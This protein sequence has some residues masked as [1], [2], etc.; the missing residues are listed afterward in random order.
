MTGFGKAENEYGGKKISVEIKSLNS[1]QMDMTLRLPNACRKYEMALRACVAQRLVRGK[2]EVTITIE[3]AAPNVSALI[4]RELL[5]SYHQQLLQTVDAL[6]IPPPNNWLDILLNMPG[7][8]QLDGY[9]I[10][11][12]EFDQIQTT[13]NQAIEKLI[14]FRRQEGSMLDA[15]FRDK[16]KR[17]TQL[18]D[19]VGTFEAER[20]IRIK[21]RLEE[22]LKQIEEKISI[23]RNRLEQEMIFYIEKLDVNEEKSRL[24]NHL[25]YFI[26]TIDA[27]EAAGR[28][29]GFIAQ[30]I[31]R[32]INT[33]GSKANQ[34]DIQQLVV[35]MKDELEQ[36][37]EQILNVL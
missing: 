14:D 13:L 20:L 26:E 16:I 27:E 30:E 17:I 4:N 1:K 35:Q 22:G 12:K 31:G 11:A 37:K 21:A 15:V 25:R 2:T 6:H 28:K 32:E 10:D 5:D 36:I 23:D 29:L 19:A 9:E 18:L 7:V 24:S 34:S 33:L 3:E 8:M